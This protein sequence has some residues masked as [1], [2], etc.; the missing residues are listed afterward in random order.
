[1]KTRKEK[2][3]NSEDK[4][5]ESKVNSPTKSSKKVARPP[6]QS[7]PQPNKKFPGS[8]KAARNLFGSPEAGPSNLDKKKILPPAAFKNPN[9]MNEDEANTIEYLQELEEQEQEIVVVKRKRPRKYVFEYDEESDGDTVF[10]GFKYHKRIKRYMM[11]IIIYP[12]C[13]KR[14]QNFGFLVR[15]L[16]Q[17]FQQIFV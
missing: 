3:K 4:L 5:P 1:M 8:L 13:L 7:A 14:N 12:N 9:Y 2:S 16:D 10:R 17:G 15:G 11:Y 6:P